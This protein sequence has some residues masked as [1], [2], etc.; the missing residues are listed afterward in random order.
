MGR[1]YWPGLV[2]GVFLSAEVP[3][4][5]SLATRSN[6]APHTTDGRRRRRPRRFVAARLRRT[7]PA[8]RGLP[9]AR[10]GRPHLAAHRARPRGV[11][12]LSRPVAG[13]LAEPRAL[14][15]GGGPD[16]A[17]HPRRPRAG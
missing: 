8:G 12:P 6:E 17:A 9:A 7:A 5:H 16:D 15:G 13:A 3:G 4:D 14:P 1:L 2:C 10:A 11:P